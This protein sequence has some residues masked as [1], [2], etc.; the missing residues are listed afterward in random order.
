MFYEYALDPQVV[1]TWGERDNY[2]FF[3]REF[4]FGRGRLV[5]RYPKKWIKKVWEHAKPKSDIEQKRLEILLKGLGEIMVKRVNPQWDGSGSDWLKNALVE[6]KR[7]P[8]HAI[9]AQENHRGPQV[10]T[11]DEVVDQHELWDL[12]HDMPVKREANEMARAI[13]GLLT[14]SKWIKF[15]DPYISKA[16]REYKR[17]ISAFL[18][19]LAGQRPVGPPFSVEL[20]AKPCGVSKDFLCDF[21]SKIIPP[22]LKVT[23]FLWNEKPGGQ[24]FHNRY[25]LGD[26]GGVAFGHGLDEGRGCEM[27]YL[28][29]LGEE[30]Y[31][32]CCKQYN[33]NSVFFDLIE[34]PLILPRD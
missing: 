32:L 18:K 33:R 17:S 30:Q 22:D 16:K 34:D 8:F 25:I 21:Y 3:K 19:I 26:I 2:R 10:I 24:K 14:Y 15:I 28:T 27:D 11:E 1:S 7:F 4:E 29:R 9:L 31:D 5:S 20:H 23:L 12:P 13:S 6:H